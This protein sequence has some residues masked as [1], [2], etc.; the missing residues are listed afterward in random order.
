M[1]VCDICGRSYDLRDPAV[2]WL[3][4]D[5]VWTCA[6]E[7]ACFDRLAIQRALDAAWARLD[8]AGWN[9]AHPSLTGQVV[10]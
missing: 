7:S 9:L 2:R 4:V 5:G 6:D 10:P 8:A 3:N 1:C